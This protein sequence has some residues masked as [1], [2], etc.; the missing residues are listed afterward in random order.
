MEMVHP[1][2]DDL[3]HGYLHMLGFDINKAVEYRAYQHRNLQGDIVVNFLISG[4]M[5]LDRKSLTSPFSTYEDRLIASQHYDKSLFEALYEMGH[6]CNDYGASTIDRNVSLREN[7]VSAE[8]VKVAEEIA[9][10]EDLLFHIRGNQRL[11]DGSIKL[12]SDYKK[13]QEP[14]VKRL[15]KKSVKK[16]VND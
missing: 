8:D 14:E 3:V 2:N 10:L 1:D 12:P 11:A 6:C 13:E 4:E 9:L 16:V 15:R 5:L 7:D